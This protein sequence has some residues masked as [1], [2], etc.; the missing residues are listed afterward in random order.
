MQTQT[1]NTS[2]AHLQMAQYKPKLQLAQ[3]HLAQ[4]SYG[5]TPKRIRNPRV[6]TQHPAPQQSGPPPGRATPPR[7]RASSPPGRTCNKQE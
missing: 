5:P 1:Q 7:V 2:Q 4:Q 6:A 3:L